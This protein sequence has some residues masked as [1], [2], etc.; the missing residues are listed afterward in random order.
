MHGKKSPYQL[1]VAFPFRRD[2]YLCYKHINR[3]N[4]FDSSEV[5]LIH[6]MTHID[7][8]LVICLQVEEHRAKKESSW[9]VEPSGNYRNLRVEDD[10]ISNDSGVNYEHDECRCQNLNKLRVRTS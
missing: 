1:P 3:R 6:I 2:Y 10:L 4:R 7:V 5:P 9:I 8:R